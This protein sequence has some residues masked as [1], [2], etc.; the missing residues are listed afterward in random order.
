MKKKDLNQCKR[1]LYKLTKQLAIW[2]KPYWITTF[3]MDIQD[4]IS[5]VAAYGDLMRSGQ[6]P[7]D[8]QEGMIKLML[9]K[10][11]EIDD[12]FGINDLS[13]NPAI[14]TLRITIKELI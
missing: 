11:D 5:R 8:D 2:N 12:L 3:K 10:V 9:K 7:E 14:I 13:S 6:I 1:E 4:L